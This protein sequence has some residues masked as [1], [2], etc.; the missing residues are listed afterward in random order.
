MD[1]LIKKLP[2]LAFVLAGFAAF[3]FTPATSSVDSATQVWAE[4]PDNPE[5]YI[6]VTEAV[7]EERYQCNS[8][9][10]ECRVTFTDDDP[11]NGT[12]TVH[13]MGEFVE[14]P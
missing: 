6:N 2:I 3:A 13:Q 8:S 12:K 1:N 10:L 11:I 4:D 14:L 9:S 7:T 5:T